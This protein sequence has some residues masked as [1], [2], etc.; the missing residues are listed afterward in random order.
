MHQRI[1]CPHVYGQG[2]V[3]KKVYQRLLQKVE[4]RPLCRT[5][6]CGG[7]EASADAEELNHRSG[8]SAILA[9]VSR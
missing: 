2:T 9:I 7:R 6:R 1:R 4:Q 8:L 3:S 5:K